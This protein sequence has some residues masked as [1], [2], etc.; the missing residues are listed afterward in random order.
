MALNNPY[1]LSFDGVD[2]YVQISSNFN[3]NSDDFYISFWAYLKNSSTYQTL[4]SL[5]YNSSEGFTIITKSGTN[6]IRLFFNGAERFVTANEY[7]DTWLPIILHRNGTT[8]NFIV[9]DEKFSMPYSGNI[10]NFDFI[11]GKSGIASQFYLNGNLDEIII[12]KGTYFLLEIQDNINKYLSEDE[13][14]LVAHYRCD[15]GSGNTLIDSSSNGNDGIIYGAT[16]VNGSVDF[17]TKFLDVAT[18]PPTDVTYDRMTLNGKLKE[19]INYPT[20]DCKF[21]YSTNPEFS[22]LNNINN[23]YALS[24]DGVDDYVEI[25]YQSALIQD[26]FTIEFFMQL[27]DKN[28]IQTFIDYGGYGSNR[29]MIKRMDDGMLRMIWGA[30]YL[31]NY[32]DFSLNSKQQMASIVR[33][34]INVYF[35]VDGE[36]LHT[37]SHANDALGQYNLILG[38][39]SDN[40][41]QF[42]E[43]GVDEIRIWN[44]SL[45]QQE[46]QNNMNIQLTGNE[47]GLVAYYRCDE[48]TGNTLIDATGNGNDGTIYGASYVPGEAE[49]ELSDNVYE[50]QETEPQTIKDTVLSFDGVDDYVDI[51]NLG[52]QTTIGTIEFM[53]DSK[54]LENYNNCF[55]TNFAGGDNAIR[56]EE[57]VN[58]RF[59]ACI[60]NSSS[61]LNHVYTNS[62]MVNTIY[63]VALVWDFSS[64]NVKG[65]LDGELVFDESHSYIPSNMSDVQIG[66]GFNTDRYWYGNINEFRIWNYDRTQSEIQYYMNKKLTGTEEGLIAYYNCDNSNNDETT[67]VD[68]SGNGNDGIING[69]TYT[70]SPENLVLPITFSKTITGLDNSKPYYYRAVATTGGEVLDNYNP[71]SLSFDGID[72]YVKVNS[73]LVKTL[74]FTVDL[75]VYLDSSERGLNKRAYLIGQNNNGWQ[76]YGLGI[77]VEFETGRLRFEWADNSS[78][79]PGTVSYQLTTDDYDEFLN[80]VFSRDT[81][82]VLYIYKEGQLVSSFQGNTIIN[83]TLDY[84]IVGGHFINSVQNSYGKHMLDEVRIWNRTLSQQEIKNNMNRRLT[85][86]EEGLVV[87]YRCDRQVN[88]GVLIDSS[89][90]DN[91]GVIYGATWVEN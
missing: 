64:N 84:T 52:N 48:G 19:I 73:I 39:R 79:D 49:L 21:Q 32:P 69:A 4:I 24:F 14:G 26:S 28:Q 11:L 45:S 29:W 75:K 25:P 70:E 42:S 35:Y 59:V 17:K 71:Y 50:I 13:E 88:H 57:N 40:N 16:Y 55:T 37:W 1:A 6:N 43:M 91:H 12:R 81:S 18:L 3:L 44:R 83:S 15:E 63:H 33:D 77:F 72:D 34:G 27:T 38:K 47:P 86:D 8:I 36:L 76:G 68:L 56:F 90:N 30:D 85:G 46:I 7:I 9:A 74:E 54:A 66:R 78:S 58:G 20:V 80:F 82:G 60:G 89:G 65:Y 67:L 10:G 22:K 51:G 62:L 61:H 31:N 2:D 41:T 87:Y 5:G 53:M 23:P